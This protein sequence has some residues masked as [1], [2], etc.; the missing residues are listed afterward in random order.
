[1]FKSLLAGGAICAALILPVTAQTVGPAARLGV[2]P[3]SA[4]AAPAP[5]PKAGTKSA[6][7]SEKLDNA[8][9]RSADLIG[10]YINVYR[11]KPE[12]QRLPQLF[13]AMVDLNMLADAESSGLYLGFVGGVLASDATNAN[14][15]IGNMFPLPPQHHAALIKAL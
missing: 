2:P 13:R 1:M 5:L 11:A 6:K 4:A 7:K 9:F 10:R 12:P 3:K 8:D 14:A 15:T